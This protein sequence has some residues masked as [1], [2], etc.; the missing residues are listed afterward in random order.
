MLTCLFRKRRARRNNSLDTHAMRASD[1]IVSRHS[2]TSL[3]PI[4]TYNMPWYSWVMPDCVRKQHPTVHWSI[5]HSAAEWIA[6]SWPWH[7]QL[8]VCPIPTSDSAFELRKRTGLH[9]KLRQSAS[10]TA[11]F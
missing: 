10:R 1:K 9:I 8:S 3:Q 11:F 2:S 4:H 7:N 5:G 6:F